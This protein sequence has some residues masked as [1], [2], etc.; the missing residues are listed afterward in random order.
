MNAR[1]FSDAPVG[2]RVDYKQNFAELKGDLLLEGKLST[3]ELASLHRAAFRAA[4]CNIALNGFGGCHGE[5]KPGREQHRRNLEIEFMAARNCILAS[6][7]WAALSPYDRSLI[8]AR[9]LT[10]RVV[11]AN[12]VS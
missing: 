11:D 1:H 10:V 6:E 2:L 7:G 12:L 3:A 9:L 5:I 4:L 8:K